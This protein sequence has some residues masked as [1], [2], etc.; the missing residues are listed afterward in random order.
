M[1]T[2]ELIALDWMAKIVSIAIVLQTVELLQIRKTFSDKGVWRWSTLRYEFEIF[3]SVVRWFLDSTLNY[4]NF[5]TILL[6]RLFA[7]VAVFFVSSS[8][9]GIVILLVCTFLILLRFRGTYNGGSDYMTL[10]ILMALTVAALS[11]GYPT[12][13][14]GCLWY[15]TIQLCLS[16]FVSGIVKLKR[17]NWW[18]GE[19]L[20]AFIKSS[21]YE[22]SRLLLRMVSNKSIIMGFSWTAIA[23]ECLFP[24]SIFNT[25]A[26]LVFICLGLL[27]HSTNFYI[28]GL[29]RFVFAWAAAYPALYYCS[30]G[31]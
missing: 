13:V 26:A 23:F 5:I 18:S 28:F 8:S 11:S 19:A 7:A 21:N 30:G 14:L 16:Y 20:R 6:L 2:P 4:P 15:V 1:L 12:V 24:I 17:N 10:I 9:W 22:S 31:F 27:F 3:P 25:T 29:N